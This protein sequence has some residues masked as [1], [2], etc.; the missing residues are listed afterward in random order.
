MRVL[1]GSEIDQWPAAALLPGPSPNRRCRG[2]MG[3]DDEPT[4]A[5]IGGTLQTGSAPRQKQR[6]QG[7]GC[8]RRAGTV[9]STTA[10]GEHGDMSANLSGVD[11]GGLRPRRRRRTR[12]FGSSMFFCP[13]G[14]AGHPG[15]SA[16][17]VNCLGG[18]VK[19]DDTVGDLTD[20]GNRSGL[21]QGE[22]LTALAQLVAEELECSWAPRHDRVPDSRGPETCAQPACRL[23]LGAIF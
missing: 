22:L 9:D 8:Q 5:R 16:P 17:E 1:P 3:G 12:G 20:F 4:S 15:C 6:R 11:S 19:P 7:G 10:D 18:S 14:C 13:A 21:G 23:S 2:S